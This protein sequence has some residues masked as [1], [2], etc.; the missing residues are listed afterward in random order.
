MASRH[1]G[2]A[3][4]AAALV[5]FGGLVGVAPATAA[6]PLNQVPAASPVAKPTPPPPVH[7]MGDYSA[8]RF[9]AAAA[10]LP[11]AMKDA[12]SRDLGLTPEQY[13]GQ[14]A[15]ARDAGDIVATLRSHGVHVVDSRLSGV[16]LHVTVASS[17][18]VAAAAATGAQVAVGSAPAAPP[19]HLKP[20]STP[21]LGGEAWGYTTGST[22]TSTTGIRCS[23]GFNGIGPSQAQ[24]FVTAGHCLAGNSPSSVYTITQSAPNDPG[25][26][27][28]TLG[29][30]TAGTVQYGGGYDSARITVTSAA[31]PP[32][33]S[34]D[35]WNGGQG[36]PSVS[37]VPVRGDIAPVVGAAMCKSGSSS[38]WTCGTIQSVQ[39]VTVGSQDV[40][41]VVSDAC[42]IEGDSGGSA[43]VGDF[44]LGTTSGS[45]NST[46]CGSSNQ[47]AFFPMRSG[48][49]SPDIET[50]QSTWELGVTLSTPTLNWPSGSRI[51]STTPL[52]GSV[53]GADS[54]TTV[55]V[56]WDGASTPSTTTHPAVDGT[57]SLTPP[58]AGSHTYRIVA[59]WGTQTSSALTGSITVAT[60]P[61]FN[62]I[63]GGDRFDTSVQIAQAAYPTTAPIV[64]VASG[65]AFPDALSAGP[66][67]VKLGGPLLLTA[68]GYLPSSVS[69][70]ISS[71]N[72]QRIVVVGGQNAVSDDVIAQLQSLEPG[73]NVTRISGGDRYATSRAIA[74]YAFQSTTS[75]FFATG[76]GFPDALAAGAAAGSI[77]APVILVP[78]SGTVD[79]QT[80]QLVRSL[81]AST[82]D[83]A[84]GTA[85]I[86][87]QYADSLTSLGTV[88]RLAGGDRFGTAQAINAAT[89]SPTRPAV[90]LA[91]GLQFPDALAGSVLAGMNRDPLYISM[92]SCIPQ[93]VV[94]EIG[95]LGAGNLTAFGGPAALDGNV[96]SLAVCSG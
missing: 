48:N 18:D 6:P 49:G 22:P 54:E 3:A 72:P 24:Q 88:Q 8:S 66:A 90:Y 35:T 74:S 19:L 25:T 70:E 81:G 36:A 15:A 84:G 30:P 4:L 51:F 39:H 31:T 13:L 80:A 79:D 17:S 21:L 96:A 12:V 77:H 63:A 33:D 42:V 86:S 20:A 28:N 57:F 44:A 26:F 76:T 91:S 5:A 41:S 9:T 92:P 94:A 89:F 71:L 68:P 37:S 65:V 55:S 58:A 64:M 53:V 62:R 60:A 69:S 95:R 83:V 46:S 45:S 43:L 67:A 32:V 52:T 27:G 73:A 56:Y 85:V 59:G 11:P 40:Y 47:A 87:Q 2:I 1:G 75:A 61:T 93:S 38:G 7:H 34:V 16:A 14:A 50:Q 82:L 78:G 29:Q 10:K 23:V